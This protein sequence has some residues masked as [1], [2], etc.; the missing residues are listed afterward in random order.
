MMV[1]LWELCND[2]MYLKKGIVSSGWEEGEGKW[3]IEEKRRGRL[4][5]AP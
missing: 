5:K 4:E 2:V 3:S 1:H